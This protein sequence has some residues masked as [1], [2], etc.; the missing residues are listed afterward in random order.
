MQLEAGGILVKLAPDFFQFEGSRQGAAPKGRRAAHA[1]GIGS[2]CQG[3]PAVKTVFVDSN[4]RA[5]FKR[6]AAK[7][8]ELYAI[9]A[10][11][12]QHHRAG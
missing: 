11:N 10:D 2:A 12:L 5:H 6:L 1:Q 3:E 8:A 7:L 4:N 9:C